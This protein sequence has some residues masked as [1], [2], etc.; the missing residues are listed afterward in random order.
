MAQNGRHFVGLGQKAFSQS[1]QTSRMCCIVLCPCYAVCL[2]EREKINISEWMWTSS[3]THTNT[4]VRNAVMF[5]VLS[6]YFYLFNDKTWL[7]CCVLLLCCCYCCCVASWIMSNANA[8]RCAPYSHLI[9]YID[10]V[11][12][13]IFIICIC[14]LNDCRD[15]L[16]CR[17]DFPSLFIGCSPFGPLCSCEIRSIRE[18]YIVLDDNGR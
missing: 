6:V 10:F 5:R 17:I 18:I 8:L 13:Y 15:R 14:L 3:L 2:L 4:H 9:L 7:S 12:F 11:I 1:R 16:L